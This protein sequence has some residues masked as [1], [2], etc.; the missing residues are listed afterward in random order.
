MRKVKIKGLPQA[1]D[2]AEVK[3][4]LWNGHQQNWPTQMNQ[5]ST[6]DIDVNQTLQPVDRSVANLEAEK[7]ERVVVNQGGIPTNFTVGGKRHSEGGTPLNLP[8]NSFVFSDTKNMKIKDP[9]I[10]AQFGITSGVH[11]PADIAKKYDINKYR[12]ILADPDSSDLQRKTSEMMI[13]NY[14]E[15][16]AKLALVQESKKGFPQGIPGIAMPYIE[17]TKMDPSSFLETQSQQ[18]PFNPDMGSAAYGGILPMAQAGVDTSKIKL[19]QFNYDTQ[20]IDA[21]KKQQE[22]ANAREEMMSSMSLTPDIFSWKALMGQ[23]GGSPEFQKSFIDFA[24]QQGVKDDAQRKKQYDIDVL[25]AGINHRVKAASDYDKDIQR[26]MGYIKSL[27]T[28]SEGTM[29]DIQR[30]ISESQLKK[31]Q[32]N[33]VELKD[34]Q[35]AVLKEAQGFKNKLGTHE[36]RFNTK[37][38]YEASLLTPYTPEKK[39]AQIAWNIANPGYKKITETKEAAPVKEAAPIKKAVPDTLGTFNG[40]PLISERDG[41]ELPEF[42][43]GGIVAWVLDKKNPANVIP[44]Y[45]DG[46]YGPSMSQAAAKVYKGEP[47][48][49][50]TTNQG[51]T[52]VQSSGKAPAEMD[53]YTPQTMTW[54]EKK[55]AEGNDILLPDVAPPGKYRLPKQHGTKAPN[56]YGKVTWSEAEQKDFKG[57]H[58]W[59]YEQR[60]NW[61]P[62][63]DNDVLW[64]QTEYDKMNPGYFNQK[65]DKGNIIQGTGLDS[66]F[67]AHTYSMPGFKKKVT[68]AID[69]AATVKDDKVAAAA[70]AK[71][72]EYAAAEQPG[73]DPWWLQDIVKTAGAAGDFFRVKKYS[74]WQATPGIDLPEPTFFDPTRELAASAEA[75]NIG[76]QGLAAFTNPQAFAAGFSQIQG[77]NAKNAADILGRY[78]NMNVGVANDFEVKRTGI[79]NDAAARRAGLE[80][81][82]ADKY[83]ILN[84]QFDNSKNMARQ[85]LR[86][87]YIDAVT[88]KNNTANMNDLYDQYKIDTSI[89]GRKRWTHGRP[90]TAEDS[91]SDMVTNINST[92]AKLM[93]QN[94]GLTRDKAVDIAT[95][96]HTG[97]DSAS[98]TGYQTDPRNGQGY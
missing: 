72:A 66:D 80:T 77:Q 9:T 33:I 17:S 74:P 53:I 71:K 91:P 37:A 10:L 86:Q 6:P 15:K 26:N 1:G 90:L 62:N 81:T 51:T 38:E 5:F 73:H 45:K 92:T 95:K 96:I 25:K 8:E 34:K 30:K 76:T 65:D 12:G 58:P 67:G 84:Q 7:G 41:G 47:A 28:S 27:M 44:K 29:P 59:I 43:N 75:A 49:Q 82:L 3:S 14:N 61:S 69:P 22:T 21:W 93:E 88:N 11:T 79:M 42:D 36:P 31:Y 48:K 2:G 35:D 64:A 20:G 83:T 4:R 56:V 16:L 40:L 24:K 32:E 89:G 87:S 97:K 60:P 98:Q 63:N 70:A 18:T 50:A 85:N 39:A 94:P 55:K 19:P 57:R 13:A 52:N 68:T 23:P 78:N 46:S 54:L